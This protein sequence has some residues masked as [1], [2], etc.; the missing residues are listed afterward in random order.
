MNKL[1]ILF[2]ALSL[3]ACQS[4]DKNQSTGTATSPSDENTRSTTPVPQTPQGPDKVSFSVNDTTART[5]K[6][7]GGDTDENL[8]IFTGNGAFL[9]LGIYGDVPQRPHRGWLAFSLKDFKFEPATYTLSK[10]NWASFTRYETIDAGG[11][12]EFLANAGPDY[13]GTEMSITFSSFE[14][15]PNSMNFRDYL[16]SGTFSVKLQNKVYSSAERAK[17]IQSVTIK[18]G[19]FEKIR[20]VG[21]PKW[22]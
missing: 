12:A 9:N 11:S 21:G 14:H 19:R 4:G 6:T 13:K 16:A 18:E 5:N 1:F 7:S 10:D 22:Q 8:G 2:T 3:I 15:D 20:I 17:G